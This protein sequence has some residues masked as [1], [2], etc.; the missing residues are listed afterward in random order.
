MKLDFKTLAIIG[1]IIVVVLMRMC[2][3][4]KTKKDINKGDIVKV[5]G[6]KYEVVD[7][8]RDTIY[9][10]RDT[11]VYKEGKTIKVKVEVPKYIPLEV[12]TQ[13]ILMD[14][15]TKRFYTDTLDLGKDSYVTIEDTVVEN[16]IFTRKFTS[17]ITERIINDTLFLKEPA[18][19]QIYLGLVGG[20]DRVNILNYAG[21]S[22]L[23]KDKKDKIFGLGVGINNS[24]QISLQGSIYWKI[25]LR[26]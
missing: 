8:K 14:Y 24:K 22:L 7:N 21:P 9:I 5:N 11:I 26:K 18:K 19:R 15:F 17:R 16:K 3:G 25:K 6:K 12:D 20:F 1:L 23:Y 2:D 4:D 13:L 10:K